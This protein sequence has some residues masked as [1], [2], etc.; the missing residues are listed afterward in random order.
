MS[1]QRLKRIQ[2]LETAEVVEYKAKK[3]P[4]ADD[5]V[6]RISSKI[7]VSPYSCDCCRDEGCSCCYLL[8]V[9]SSGVATQTP[10]TKNSNVA[11][12]A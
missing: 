9:Q 2:R 4:S 11:T 8:L 5:W 10:V 3:A 12:G 6:D 1:N 7:Y